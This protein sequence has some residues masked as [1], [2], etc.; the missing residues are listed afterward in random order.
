MVKTLWLNPKRLERVLR[1]QGLQANPYKFWVGDLKEIVKMDEE[2]NSKPMMSLSHDL[3]PRLFSFVLHMLHK[4]G[5]N[6]FL[7]YGPTPGLII[8]S[9]ELF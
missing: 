9:P 7:G 6:S 2:T 5:K 1:E 4:Y 3:F 8:T